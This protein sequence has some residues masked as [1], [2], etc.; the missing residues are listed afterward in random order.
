MRSITFTALTLSLFFG[1][2]GAAIAQQQN[3]QMQNMPGMDHS[4]MQG[5]DMHAMMTRCAQMRQ[6]MRPG[7]AV[8]ADRRQM[9]AQCGQMDRSMGMAPQRTR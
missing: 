4:Q 7:A 3:G 8:P 5:M 9:M 2:A 1:V 6:G